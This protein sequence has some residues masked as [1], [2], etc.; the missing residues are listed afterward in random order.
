[1]FTYCFV[2]KYLFGK[3]D[4]HVRMSGS[5]R[6]CVACWTWPLFTLLQPYQPYLWD[7]I[8]SWSSMH[9]ECGK[10]QDSRTCSRK[11]SAWPHSHFCQICGSGKRSKACLHM[12]FMQSVWNSPEYLSL[13]LFGHACPVWLRL[14]ANAEVIHSFTVI[15]WSVHELKLFF[16]GGEKKKFIETVQ[17]LFG[18]TS[19]DGTRADSAK[20]KDDHWPGGWDRPASDPWVTCWPSP[21]LFVTEHLIQ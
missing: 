21:W 14:K 6:Q 5:V 3:T 15:W 18:L 17:S 13:S 8:M 7:A 11:C 9:H 19:V 4:K 12:V 1:M 2:D 10:L 16:I 20:S